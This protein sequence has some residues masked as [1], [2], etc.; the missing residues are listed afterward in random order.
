MTA[1]RRVFRRLPGVGLYTIF[2]LFKE[3]AHESVIRV[4]PPPLYCPHY[5]NT[6]SRPLC[7]VRPPP[8]PAPACVRHAPYDIGNDNIV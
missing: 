1:D 7:D 8:A 6:N 2:V 3:L 5:C 4:F